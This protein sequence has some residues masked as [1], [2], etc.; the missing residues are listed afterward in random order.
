MLFLVQK[1]EIYKYNNSQ[2][3]NY[4]WPNK[5]NWKIPICKTG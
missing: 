1:N 4:K 5:V 3:E 2:K